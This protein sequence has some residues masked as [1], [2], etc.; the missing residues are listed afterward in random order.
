MSREPTTT[1]ASSETPFANELPEEPVVSVVTCPHAV[2]ANAAIAAASGF[3]THFFRIA[4][5]IVC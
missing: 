1:E 2:P 3:K 5:S 4:F